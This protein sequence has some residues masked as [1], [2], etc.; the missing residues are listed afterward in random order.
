MLVA[1][2]TSLKSYGCRVLQSNYLYF[3]FIKITIS[4]IEIVYLSM[5]Y[6]IT[7]KKIT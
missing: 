2:L 4:A 1:T 5:L 7:F 6:M 3:L